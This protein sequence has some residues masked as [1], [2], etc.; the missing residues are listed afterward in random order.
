[1]PGKSKKCLRCREAKPFSEFHKNRSEPDGAAVY[2]KACARVRDKFYNDHRREVYKKYGLSLKDYAGLLERQ[3][4]KCAV[5]RGGNNGVRFAVDHDHQTGKIRGLL[6]TGCNIGIG[7]FKEDPR[8]MLR[9]IRYLRQHGRQKG[10][11]A[12]PGFG[13]VLNK[14]RYVEY[15]N[16]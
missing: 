4:G 9:A 8:T 13:D 5:C 16:E 12:P 6:C 10:S 11:Q 14:I 15:K 2:C 1:M 3:G 7:Q